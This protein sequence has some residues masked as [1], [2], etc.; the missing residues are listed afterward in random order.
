MGFNHFVDFNR[1]MLFSRH[2]EVQKFKFEQNLKTSNSRMA[3]VCDVIYLTIVSNTMDHENQLD[4][5]WFRLIESTNEVYY[6]Y[7]ISS[8]SDEFCRKLEGVLWWPSIATPFKVKTNINRD[9][10]TLKLT[11]KL[12]S[13]L[14]MFN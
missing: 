11:F 10:N 6:M 5:T 9:I 13:K 7:Q 14:S 4:T 12:N 2:F 8:Q 1:L 3:G